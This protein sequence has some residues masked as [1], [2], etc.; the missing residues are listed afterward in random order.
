M[1]RSRGSGSAIWPGGPIRSSRGASGS[2]VSIARAL[3][4]EARILLLDE[5][6]TGLDYGNQWRLL[7]LVRE[8]AA[9]G[10]AVVQSTHYPDHVLGAAD[11]AVLLHGGRIVADGVPDAVVTPG[12]H[13]HPVRA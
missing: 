11:R 1:G 2:C 5:P 7:A 13:P 10:R 3:V 6:A 8:L 9:E 4:Q 12:Q